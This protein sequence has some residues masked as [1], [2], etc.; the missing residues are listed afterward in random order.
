MSKTVKIS[1]I[2]LAVLVVLS[3]IILYSKN[4]SDTIMKNMAIEAIDPD[5]LASSTDSSDAAID[6]D[7]AKV[8]GQLSGLDTAATDVDESFKQ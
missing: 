6:G 7:M 4:S 2:V 3:G 1:L 8:S 5:L